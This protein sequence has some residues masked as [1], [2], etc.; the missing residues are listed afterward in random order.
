[1]SDMKYINKHIKTLAYG[2]LLLMLFLFSISYTTFNVITDRQAVSQSQTAVGEKMTFEVSNADVTMKAQMTDKNKDVLILTMSVQENGRKLPSN[3]SD[4]WVVTSSNI[5]GDSIPTF[6]GRMST[7]GDFY[8]IIPYPDKKM[9]Y[10]IGIYN[11]ASAKNEAVTSGNNTVRV[12]SGTQASIISD[13]TSDIAKNKNKSIVST[14]K[15]DTIGFNASLN[16]A[17]K[18][19]EYSLTTLDV[20]S[21]LVEKNGVVSFD[22]ETFYELAYRKVTVDQAQANVDDIEAQIEVKNSEL[23]PLQETLEINPDDRVA[24]ER[25]EDLNAELTSLNG[26]LLEA[27]ETLSEVRKLKFKASDFDDY[28]TKMYKIK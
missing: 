20:D 1:M 4:Y 28:T 25:Q 8:L 16:S 3:A 12:S 19:E 2:F 14:K 26:K 17:I 13:I 23:A 21:L 11:T 15:S 5:S 27:S 22:F 7:D 9:T 18:S 24:I 6:F 10:T